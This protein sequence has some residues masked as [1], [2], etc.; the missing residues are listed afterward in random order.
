MDRATVFLVSCLIALTGCSALSRNPVPIDQIER[1]EV[2]GMPHVRAFGDRLARAEEDALL[3]ESREAG[4]GTTPHAKGTT[5]FNALV[6]SAGSYKGAFG[7]GFLRGWSATGVRPQFQVVTGVS[8]GA[9]T[10]PFAFLGPEY[11]QDLERLIATV[12]RKDIYEKRPSREAL[13]DDEPLMRLISQHI[14]EGMLRAIAEAHQRGRRLYVATTNLDAQRLVIWDLGAIAS[15][16]HPEALRLLHQVLLASAAIPVMFR[17]VLIDVVVD[18]MHY[19]EM[20]VDG[21]IIAREFFPAGMFDFSTGPRQAAVDGTTQRGRG[22][23]Y[24]VLNDQVAPESRPIE[25]KLLGMLSRTYHTIMKTGVLNDLFRIYTLARADGNDVRYVT[26]PVD[27]KYQT[28]ASFDTGEIRR[29]YWEGYRLA[30][31]DKPWSSKLPS[32]R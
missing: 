30:T 32:F 10:A 25:R 5:A 23:I 27:F 28:K 14:H 26:I 2:P 12:D 17:P 15:S 24:V 19:D 1:A 20:H 4:G 3:V 31:S 9:L 11:D 18:G 13:A 16:G 8:A 22:T 29:L 6:L 7:A 21:G